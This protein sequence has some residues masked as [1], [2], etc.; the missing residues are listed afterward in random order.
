MDKM[1]TLAPVTEIREIRKDLFMLTFESK[2]I[3]EKAVCGQFV[4][5]KC[6]EGVYLRRPISIFSVENN[7]VTIIFEVRGN[8]TKALSEKNVGNLIDVIGPLGNGYSLSKLKDKKVWLIGG[9]I[10]VFPLYM[11]AKEFKENSE[12]VLGFKNADLVVTEKDFAFTGSSVTVVTD[13][14][15]MG[16]KGFVT[17]IFRKKLLN[18]K[19]DA[20]LACGPMVMLKAVSEICKENGIFCEI[21]LEERMACGLGACLCCITPVKV[22]DEVENLTV[23]RHGPVFNA[24]EVF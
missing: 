20:V 23:C 18:G 10:G 8:G 1:V 13:D 5:I 2:E 22:A 24:T 17:D 7:N 19:P 4:H 14:G 15:S 21:S 6:G 9:G 16:E 12:T 11:A 3:A